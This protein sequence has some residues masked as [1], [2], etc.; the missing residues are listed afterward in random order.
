MAPAGQTHIV[1]WLS[2]TC[3]AACTTK[4]SIKVRSER[5]RGEDHDSFHTLSGWLASANSTP[6][7]FTLETHLRA[8]MYRGK[9]QSTGIAA[10]KT[11]FN[12]G[13][14]RQKG[15]AGILLLKSTSITTL[16][17]FPAEILQRV[18]RTLQ[19]SGCV[20]KSQPRYWDVA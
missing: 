14:S 16:E 6:V 9:L 7:S 17:I 1:M 13:E 8:A 11:F 18:T 12:P 20:Q 4:Q 3:P 2:G 10:I 5:E 15:R 19:C